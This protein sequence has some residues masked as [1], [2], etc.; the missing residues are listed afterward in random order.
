MARG[1]AGF[2]R[3]V[4]EMGGHGVSPVEFPRYD[5]PWLEGRPRWNRGN[6]PAMDCIVEIAVEKGTEGSRTHPFKRVVREKMGVFAIF[7]GGADKLF[8]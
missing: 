4:F 3:A 7:P 6:L 1:L 2:A 5:P 8:G